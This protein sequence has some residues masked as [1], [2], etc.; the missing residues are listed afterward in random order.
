[1]PRL[2][3]IT[4][5]PIKSLPGVQVESI[6]VLASGAL[7]WDRR[8]EIVDAA[9]DVINAKRTPQVHHLRAAFDLS[10]ESVALAVDDH[11]ATTFSLAHDG[12]AIEAWLSRS[13]AEPVRL[14]EN[15][16]A[17]FPDDT[18]S[19]G[20]TLVS[21]AS[22][23]SVASWFPQFP[24]DQIERRFRANLVIEDAEPFWEDRLCG[25]PGESVPFRLGEVRFEGTNPC[26]RCVVPTRNPETGDTWQGFAKTFA[27]HREDTL[28]AWA[29]RAR[30]DHFYRLTL[31]TRPALGHVGG[32][33]RVGDELVV[34]GN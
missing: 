4:V 31:N 11:T 18:D 24:A 10:A 29:P 5:Y 23:A 13:F 32:T 28:P 21:R 2:A 12:E 17:G 14:I 15:V 7:A 3:S 33:L 20:P 34:D 16:A 8:W 22:L 27:R 1:M 9:G 26:Q 30:F 6:D 25:E 19:P